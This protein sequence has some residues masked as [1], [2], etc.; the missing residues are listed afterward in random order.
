V[1]LKISDALKNNDI[2]F[3]WVKELGLSVVI[4][5][6]LLLSLDWTAFVKD[7][8]DDEKLSN[9]SNIWALKVSLGLV[10]MFFT[11]LL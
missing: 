5:K 6:K 11:K 7:G 2:K 1:R 9:Y 10:L 3:F 4:K 8:F